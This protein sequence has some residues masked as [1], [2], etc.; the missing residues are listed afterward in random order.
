[1]STLHV[2]HVSTLCDYEP[3]WRAMQSFTAQRNLHTPDELWLLQHTPTYTL[4]QTGN[5]QHVHHAGNIPLIQ[6]DRGGH[7][8]WHGPG[9]LMIYTLLDTRR[10]QR[11]PKFLIN[12]LEHAIISTLNVLGIDSI[13]KPDAPGVYVHINQ[14]LHKIAAVGLRLRQKGCYHGAA[15]NL[16]CDLSAFTG[17]DPCGHAGQAITRV[18]DLAKKDWTVQSVGQ[19]IAQ[20]VQQQ[21]GYDSA[22]YSTV[23]SIDP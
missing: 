2:R 19:A 11:G 15:L 4:G 21:L 22:E 18:S 8:T 16:D 17:I 10:L 9:Q 5:T 23:D 20:A 1:M 6:T 12:A 3:V 14:S 7:V 13:S